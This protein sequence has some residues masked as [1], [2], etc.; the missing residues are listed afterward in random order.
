MIIVICILSNRSTDV[1]L[2]PTKVRNISVFHHS[3]ESN[4][5]GTTDGRIEEEDEGV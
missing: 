5:S 4:S 2:D 3:T 1:L